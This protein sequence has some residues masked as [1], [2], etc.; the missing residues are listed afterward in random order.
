MAE[1]N[2]NTTAKIEVTGRK[3]ERFSRKEKVIN[4]KFVLE[5]V[6]CRLSASSIITK[7]QNYE[8]KVSHLGIHAW[9]T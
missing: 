5:R 1:W 4:T 3:R 2:G 8:N 9:L 6:S 7:A